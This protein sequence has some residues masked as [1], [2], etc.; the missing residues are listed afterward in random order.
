MD[1]GKYTRRQKIEKLVEGQIILDAEDVIRGRFKGAPVKIPEDEAVPGIF[2]IKTWKLW[3]RERLM[4]PEGELMKH[5]CIALM[6]PECMWRGWGWISGSVLVW[7]CT[8]AR[9]FTI[10][11]G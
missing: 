4:I 11:W 5:T 10:D 9:L 2:F 1:K 6:R 8:P 3:W 7:V